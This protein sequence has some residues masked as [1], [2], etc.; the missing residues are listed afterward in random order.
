MRQ[1]KTGGGIPSKYLLTLMS[2]LCIMLL[3]VSYSTGFSG[4]PLTVIANHIFIPM[5]KG[6]DFIG[7]TISVTS[8]DTKTKEELI[9]ENEALVAQVEELNSQIDSLKLQLDELS[10]LQELYEMD[11]AYYDY[12][13]ALHMYYMSDESNT[14][15]IN[16]YTG[17]RS[18]YEWT[19]PFR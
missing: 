10:E 9:E 1:R 14:V 7:Q 19:N 2:I 3:F 18:Q 8:A 17:E 5:Q 13:D 4:G 16:P 12:R 6:I 11:Q 15:L